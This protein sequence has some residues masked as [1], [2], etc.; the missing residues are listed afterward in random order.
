MQHL[1]APLSN[2]LSHHCCL[3]VAKHLAA[4]CSK[5][6]LDAS[7]SSRDPPYSTTFTSWRAIAIFTK[8]VVKDL[9][10]DTTHTLGVPS[11]SSKPLVLS[12][13]QQLQSCGLLQNIPVVLQA[14]A[15]LLQDRPVTDATAAAATGLT[16]AAA[17]ESAGRSNGSQA[18]NHS[19]PPSSKESSAAVGKPHDLVATVSTLMV[20]AP[21][22]AIVKE[23]QSD[24]V[25]HSDIMEAASCL[26]LAFM[27]HLTSVLA[28]TPAGPPSQTASLY[29]SAA[30][31]CFY[32]LLSWASRTKTHNCGLQQPAFAATAASLLGFM[33]F[34]QASSSANKQVS[35]LPGD[36]TSA[37]S[38]SDAATAAAA[39]TAVTSSRSKASNWQSQ[40]G[41]L[42]PGL[43]Q[44][45]SLLQ[46][47]GPAAGAD[48]CC[49][50]TG[51]SMQALSWAGLWGL[52]DVS[53]VSEAASYASNAVQRCCFY[54]VLELGGQQQQQPGL[55]QGCTPWLAQ[56]K[57]TSVPQPYRSLLLAQLLMCSVED[58]NYGAA[59]QLAEWA[60]KFTIKHQEVQQQ[61]YCTLLGAWLQ[62]V[63]PVLLRLMSHAV[64]LLDQASTELDGSSS[65]TGGSAA[66]G[67]PTQRADAD[68]P[69]QARMRG[70]LQFLV[71]VAAATSQNRENPAAGRCAGQTATTADPSPH[72]QVARDALSATRH[73]YA[74][75]W[76]THSTELSRVLEGLLRVLGRQP[77]TSFT[78]QML[79][80][81]CNQRAQV[82]VCSSRGV[83]PASSFTCA[84]N[85][86]Q[87]LQQ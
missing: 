36:G 57:G 21:R 26:A 9:T 51:V 67:R 84:I 3:Q 25:Q 65:S 17:A 68:T 18:C 45:D 58:I 44:Q 62:P 53:L 29:R 56:L 20:A 63:L 14:A 24:G 83:V 87:W 4:L 43:Q 2:C 27:Q 72:L 19:S 34:A 33:A 32:L 48:L 77:V 50:V 38:C 52:Q 10:S 6:Q 59:A 78:C 12:V 28:A 70:L 47:A 11:Y 61:D 86:A 42:G 37:V 74:A 30:T 80:L 8:T 31:D 66:V 46:G 69:Q 76:Q 7:N 39:C 15:K 60:V 35:I 75:S 64:Q 79:K 23:S 16:A 22:F 55:N 41:W 49:L 71:V 81:I 13:A 1:C 40:F 85:Q 73:W 82:V 54:E 5:Y